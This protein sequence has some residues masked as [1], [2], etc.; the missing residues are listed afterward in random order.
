[1]ALDRDDKEGALIVKGARLTCCRV[2]G[3]KSAVQQGP[4]FVMI[5]GRHGFSGYPIRSLR[6]FRLTCIAMGGGPDIQLVPSQP[7]NNHR[8]A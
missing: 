5:V 3:Y 1:M 8:S 4:G 2:T 7:I 6:A